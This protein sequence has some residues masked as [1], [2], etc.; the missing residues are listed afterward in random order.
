MAWRRLG[1]K[2]LFEPM[3]VSLLTNICVT[4]PRWVKCCPHSTIQLWLYSISPDFA[5][6]VSPRHEFKVVLW[7]LVIWICRSTCRISHWYANFIAKS[8]R[9]ETSWDL[10]II[11]LSVY[12]GWIR[13]MPLKSSTQAIISVKAK[14]FPVTYYDKNTRRIPI[15]INVR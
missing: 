4:R 7:L 12:R 1:D 6:S 3:M 2:P 15:Q 10:V 11:P 9:F 13:P 14:S 5:K 8:R